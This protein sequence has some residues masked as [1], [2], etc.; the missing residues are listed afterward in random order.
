[1]K[2]YGV[3]ILVACYLLGQFIGDVLG[4]ITNINGNVGGVGFGMIALILLLDWMKKK[5]YLDLEA[6]SGIQFW[7]AMYIPIVIAMSA[8]QNVNAAI[9][10][11]LAALCIG[12]IATGFALALVPFVAKIKL[13]NKL[14][15]E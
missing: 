7:N 1:M 3:A 11:G 8:I 9:S 15:I 6:S 13:N 4:L 2:I 12:V 14:D 10:G 5:N